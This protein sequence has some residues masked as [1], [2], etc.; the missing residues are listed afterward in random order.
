MDPVIA[1]AL[2][3]GRTNEIRAGVAAARARQLGS[4][5]H[6]QRRRLFLEVSGAGRGQVYQPARRRLRDPKAA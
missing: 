2:V 3:T 1:Q 5:Q 4:S 6:G